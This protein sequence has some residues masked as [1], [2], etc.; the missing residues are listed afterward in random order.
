ME[1]RDAEGFE[2][3]RGSASRMGLRLTERAQIGQTR[4]AVRK[5]SADERAALVRAGAVQVGRRFAGKFA[6]RFDGEGLGPRAAAEAAI[7][8]LV[9]D[10]LRALL[11]PLAEPHRKTPAARRLA[12]M[13]PP[14]DPKKARPRSKRRGRAAKA[15]AI[16]DPLAHL[17]RAVVP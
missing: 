6:A 8:D 1:T 15:E 12:P 11:A 3:G 14:G 5:L 16:P 13:P 17:K 4:G 9:R 7:V 10:G 2:E